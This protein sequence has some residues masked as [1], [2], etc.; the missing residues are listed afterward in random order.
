MI[1]RTGISCLLTSDKRKR[2]L[3]SFSVLAMIVLIP[4][5]IMGQSNGNMTSINTEK[6]LQLRILK[7][8]YMQFIHAQLV[9]YYPEELDN[10]AI[11]YIVLSNIFDLSINRDSSPILDTLSKLG[12]DYE[13]ETRP[14]MVIIKIN[15]LPDK[16]PV[17]IDFLKKLYDFRPFSVK[18][19]NI[20]DYDDR[21]QN[22]PTARQRFS[23][24]ISNFWKLFYKIKD[25][26]SLIASQI[27]NHYFFPGYLIGRSMVTPKLV[28]SVTLEQAKSFYKNTFQLYNSRLILKGN[29]DNPYFVHGSIAVAFA[30]L[31]K[32]MPYIE[33]EATGKISI[34]AE[35]KIVVFNVDDGDY[36]L[37]YWFEAIPTDNKNSPLPD[38][39]FNNM[40]F[41][42]PTGRLFITARGE[43]MGHIQLET[44]MDTYKNASVIC[45]TVRLRYKDIEPFILMEEREN[46]KL[47][48]ENVPKAEFLSTLSNIS[49]RLQ[50]N[51]ENY[52]NDVSMH[53]IS[54]PSSNTPLNQLSLAGFKSISDTPDRNVI[55]IVCNYALLL[56]YLNILKRQVEVIDFN[57]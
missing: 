24:S 36:P 29:I 48:N 39:I 14:D 15:F 31:K 55:V 25:W 10:P 12:N 47:R 49:G 23:D 41:S 16:L 3:L 4:T 37:I 38:L 52:E 27:A 2:K 28:K 57:Q 54:A 5:V 33:A 20:D 44:E 46:K 19:S 45:N 35:K 30:H 42:Y 51:S 32:H 43:N 11:P 50:V 21:Q 9:I 34:S 6:G 40:L 18:D 53:I 17:F 1:Y 26:K 22:R 7:D 8:P 13:L 56:P